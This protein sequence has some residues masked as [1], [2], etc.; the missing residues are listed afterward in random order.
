MIISTQTRQ[1]VIRW[2]RLF[3]VTALTVGGLDLLNGTTR[4]SWAAVRAIIVAT[5]ETLVR[6]MYPVQPVKPE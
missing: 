2:V 5:V 4:P 6:A 1:Q 3:A